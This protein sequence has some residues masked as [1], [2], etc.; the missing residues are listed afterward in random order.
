MPFH[1]RNKHKGHYN[2]GALSAANPAL[3]ALIIRNQDGEKTLDFTDPQAV[4]ELNRALLQLQYGVTDWDIPEGY[5][6]PPIPGRADLIHAIADLLGESHD[7]HIPT[8]PGL[9]GLD[10]GTGANLVYP[11]IGQHEYQWHFV[12]SEIDQAALDNAARIL[13]ANAR[14]Q[15]QISLRK[16]ADPEAI[17]SGIVA[18]DEQFDFSLCNPPF[19]ANKGE[20]NAATE[21][22]WRNLGKDKIVDGPKLNFGGQSTEL[23]TQGGE[24]GFLGRMITESAGIARQVFW[25]TTL[26]SKAALLSDLEQQL[27]ALGATDIRVVSLAQGQKQ[28][29]LLAWTFLDK[30]QRR[31]W[32]KARWPNAASRAPLAVRH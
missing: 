8:G 31:A 16:Q 7:G 6:C 11:L 10:I 1:P 19:H 12:G 4:K 26:V 29:R 27:K 3:K 32:R 9:S 25:F 18:A 5:L 13:A 30:K 28:S 23:I 2:L 17:F 20:A 14:L 22:K 15:G 21:R 24:A